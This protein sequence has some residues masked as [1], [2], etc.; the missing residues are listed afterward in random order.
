MRA[1]PVLLVVGLLAA[2]VLAWFHG[3]KGAQRGSSMD[4]HAHGD[5]R[6]RGRRSRAGGHG[7]GGRPPPGTAALASAIT[8]DAPVAEQ[9]S[10]AVLPLVNMSG[11]ENYFKRP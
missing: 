3:A 2:V 6:H 10:I 1:L 11:D 9:G 5:P 4:R 7:R 8:A